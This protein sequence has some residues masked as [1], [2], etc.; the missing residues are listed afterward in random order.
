LIAKR[1]KMQGF[2]VG[3][4]FATYAKNFADDVSKWLK[5]GKIKTVEYVS[6]GLESAPK[7]FIGLLQGHNVGKLVVHVADAEKVE[8][9]EE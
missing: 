5:E 3:D 1:V 7:A 4:Y 2:L 9:K 6:E 8:K